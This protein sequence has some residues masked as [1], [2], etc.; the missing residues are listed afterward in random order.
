VCLKGAHFDGNQFAM[1]ALSLGCRY[2][3]TE[4]QELHGRPGCIVVEDVLKTL[5]QLALYHRKQCHIPVIGVTGTNGKTTTKEL[6]HAVLSTK[7]KTVCTKGNLNNHIGVPLTL[8]SITNEDEI[9]IIEMGANHPGEIAE[10]CELA[11]PDY[12][13]VTNIGHAHLEGFGSFENIKTT[14]FAL[15]DAVVKANGTIFI[16]ADDSVLMSYPHQEKV[17]YY[18]ENECKGVHGKVEKM[19]PRLTLTL[20]GESLTTQMTGHYNLCNILAAAATGV[21]FGVEEALIRHAIAHYQP[22]NQRSQI[23]EKGTTTFIADYYNANPD[24]MRQA[25][26][27]LAQIDFPLKK[28]ILGDMLELGTESLQAHQE[29]VKLTEELKIET[30][31]VGKEFIRT[32]SE[33][34]RFFETLEALNSV[35]SIKDYE[36]CLTLVK[37]S[38]GI[39]LEKLSVLQ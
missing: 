3:I 17:C 35:I 10:L 19:D 7:Y 12:G 30:C 8:L 34:G 33:K 22:D 18:A 1:K 29:I 27:N 5:Q 2:V 9:A 20:F 38:R 4:N 13:I 6:I 24:S 23:I 26:W 28:A 32:A 16:H 31:F 36:N 37:G 21:Y 15:Y 14:K 39:H 25:L 11:L